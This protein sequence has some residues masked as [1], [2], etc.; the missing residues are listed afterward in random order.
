VWIK[1]KMRTLFLC[2]T[3]LMGSIVGAPMRPEE[4]EDLMHTMNQQRIAYTIRAEGEEGD[5]IT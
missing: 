1:H 4:I 2:L 5:D 3:L